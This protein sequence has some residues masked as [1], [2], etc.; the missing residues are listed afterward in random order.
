MKDTYKDHLQLSNDSIQTSD[1]SASS[2]PRLASNLHS[3]K[4]PEEKS[5]NCIKE[6]YDYNYIEE[7]KVISG[8]L[9]E[10]NYIGM[11][12]EFPGIVYK[13]EKNIKDDFYY[14]ALKMNADRLK[15]IQLGITLT[16]EYGDYPQNIPY[17]TWQFNFEF[18]INKENYNEESINLLKK[19][20]IDFDKLKKHGIK[21][22]NFAAYLTT[23]GLVLN[24]DVN[25]ISYHGAYDFGYILS[26]L[27]NEKLPKTEE[28]FL[29]I[30]KLYFHKFYDIKL[31]IQDLSFLDGGLNK[32]VDKLGLKRKGIMHQAG[33]DSI[34]TVE[35]FLF[36]FKKGFINDAKI[37][38]A[39]NELY[40]IGNRR[41]NENTRKYIY[42]N[43][44]NMNCE[45]TQ[46]RNIY[47]YNMKQSQN[48]IF[49]NY[50]SNNTC[51]SNNNNNFKY[52]WFCPFMFFGNYGMMQNCNSNCNGYMNFMNN[53]NNCLMTNCNEIM[54]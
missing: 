54:A 52:N 7:L 47:T 53:N 21:K 22:N 27:L 42:G 4:F 50:N 19:S 37:F 45:E 38:Q 9:D 36:L 20:G 12:T 17:H 26:L 15:I 11:D 44:S 1:S 6:V 51:C 3:E 30:L 23:S 34:A 18:D 39:K 28:D 13:E 14:K 25:W 10:Y 35:S 46:E 48:N 40:G 43:D 33:S 24:P 31:L 16:N 29:E 49:S 2:S 8:L 41:D 32:L 5:S